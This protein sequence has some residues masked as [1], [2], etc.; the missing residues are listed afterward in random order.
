MKK[1]R[2]TVLASIFISVCLLIGCDQSDSSM[3]DTSTEQAVSTSTSIG[4]DAPRTAVYENMFKE[5]NQQYE[6]GQLDAASGT[7]QMLLQNDLSAEPTLKQD[8]E[9]LQKEIHLAQAKE[10]K[11]QTLTKISKDTSY[12]TERIS[13]LA[14]E[15]FKEDTGGD[16]VS[17]SDEEIQTWL[18]NK[19]SSTERRVSS[20][21]PE[22]QSTK[23]VLEGMEEQEQ[24]LMEVTEQIGI[25][26]SE[27]EFFVIKTD[28]HVYQV[29]IRQ[30][31]EVEDVSIS[32]MIGIFRYHF[33]TKRLEKMD[34]LTGEFNRYIKQ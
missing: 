31:M 18:E 5:A 19:K 23:I 26:A 30:G 11:N 28:A 12:Q 7:L 6:E 27:Y 10:E 13:S 2:Y 33:D 8:A 14:S 24:V 21:K 20:K 4:Q 25:D 29:E 34:P 32:T 22:K 1:N 3:S 9:T 16:I 17:A 15:E